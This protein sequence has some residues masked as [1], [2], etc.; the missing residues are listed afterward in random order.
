MCKCGAHD[1]A[2]RGR[3]W[4]RNRRDTARCR[5]SRD[6]P[7]HVTAWARDGRPDFRVAQRPTATITVP[8]RLSRN[9]VRVPRCDGPGRTC[10]ADEFPARAGEHRC[11]HGQLDVCAAD[12]GAVRRPRNC[13]RHPRRAPVGA[14][15]QRAQEPTGGG[16]NHH[17]DRKRS[18]CRSKGHGIRGR[19]ARGCG[20]RGR[21]ARDLGARVPA[22]RRATDRTTSPSPYRHAEASSTGL[23]FADPRDRDIWRAATQCVGRAHFGEPGRRAARRIDERKR[24]RHVLRCAV[25]IA[26]ADRA[27]RW[28]LATRPPRSSR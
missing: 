1:L 5:R 8:V 25:R 24:R 20:N 16:R 7:H 27:R 19:A 28:I 4:Q 11:T 22:G 26:S 6:V 17:M 21:D 2:C 15:R 18:A 23:E 10:H 13:R 12:R 14:R 9:L 3:V